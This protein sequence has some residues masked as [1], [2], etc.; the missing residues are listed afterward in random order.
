MT[1]FRIANLVLLAA[2]TSGC[3]TS[4]NVAVDPKS[5]SDRSKFDADYKECQ[6]IAETYDLTKDTQTNAV[7]GAAAGSAAVAGIATA[8]A[9]AVFAPAIPFIIAGGAAGGGLGGGLT[10]SKES[11]AREKIMGQCLNSRGYQSFATK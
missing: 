2:L 7:L 1:T 4:I 9:G 6:Q 11:E 3:A 8:V 5:I 10:K